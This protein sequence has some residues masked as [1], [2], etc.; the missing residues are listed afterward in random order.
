MRSDELRACFILNLAGLREVS[1]EA[2]VIV[3]LAKLCRIGKVLEGLR[4]HGIVLGPPPPPV[5]A[6]ADANANDESADCPVSTEGMS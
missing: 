1:A 3:S 5:D 6:D 4:V 2:L